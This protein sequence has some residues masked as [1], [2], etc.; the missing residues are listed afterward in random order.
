MED[1]IDICLR[2]A[3]SHRE[4]GFKF[5]DEEVEEK[6]VAQSSID[7]GNDLVRIIVLHVWR[8]KVPPSMPMIVSRHH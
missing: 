5:F 8:F 2:L 7:E 4:Y 6:D 3:E 1:A